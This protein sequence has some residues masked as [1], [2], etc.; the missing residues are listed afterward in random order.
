MGQ[1]KVVK[2]VCH[3]RDASLLE[4]LISTFRKLLVDIDWIYGRAVDESGLYELYLGL[5]ESRNFL[6]AVLDL[7][8]TVNVLSVQVFDEADFS[9]Y[10]SAEENGITE[11]VKIYIPKE[12]RSDCY[13]WGE[14][15]G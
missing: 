2:V 14:R 12:S 8:T 13:S 4:G 7:S 5:R 11:L 9:S 10:S 3:Y 6:A 15:C 1:R